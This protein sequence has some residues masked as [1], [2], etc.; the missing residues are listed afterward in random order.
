M[1]HLLLSLIPASFI[2]I[3]PLVL[4]GCST[5]Y[6]KTTPSQSAVLGGTKSQFINELGIP[7]A[8]YMNGF[9]LF[10]DKGNEV[11]AHFQGGKADALFYYTFTKQITEPWLSSTLTLNSKGVPWVL[12]ASSRSGRK[13]YHTSD[14]KFHAFLSS[15][16]QL[17]V[18]S[19]AFFRKSIH[20]PGQTILIDDLPECIFAPDHNSA[21]IGSTE[22]SVIRNY[23]LP[24]ATASDGAKEYNDGYQSIVVHYK[25]GRSDAVLYGTVKH[26]RFSGCWISCLQQLNSLNAWLVAECSKPNSVYYW[27]PRDSLVG[28]LIKRRSL[29]VYTQSYGKEKIEGSGNTDPHKNHFT[30]SVTPCARVWLDE[31]ESSMT[32]KLG[33]PT[34][35]NQVRVYRDSDLIIRATFD[36]GICNRIIYISAKKQKFTDHWISATLAVNSR[37]RCWFEFQDSTPRKTFY[38][39]YDHKFYARL[40]NGT[41][42]GIMTEA[43]YKKANSKLSG[44]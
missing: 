13:S 42:L 16:N 17:L 23:G 41:D 15:G 34:L 20:R 31:T 40:K 12:E 28:H 8:Q 1:R 26:V 11:Q 27:T 30:A 9:F 14:G 5:V 3:P 25:N 24:I 44:S 4:T 33:A 38:K 43:V 7:T 35:D 6:Q 21:K 10:H 36:H 32:K 19:D 37:G 2:L 39:T 18:S 22:A 29:I